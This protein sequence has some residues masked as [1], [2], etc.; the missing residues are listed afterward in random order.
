M[1]KLLDEAVW[2]HKPAGLIALAPGQKSA[3]TSLDVLS[4]CLLYIL[5]FSLNQSCQ[6]SALPAELHSLILYNYALLQLRPTI[7]LSL[8]SLSK[9]CNTYLLQTLEWQEHLVRVSA[10][11]VL[12][13]LVNKCLDRT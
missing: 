2:D 5:S 10:Q 12:A 1:S 11:K 8:S 6:P 4:V 3:S 9:I 13:S 7:L